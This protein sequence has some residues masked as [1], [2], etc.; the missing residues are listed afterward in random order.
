MVLK[1]NCTSPPKPIWGTFATGTIWLFESADG[2]LHWSPRGARPLATAASVAAGTGYASEEGANENDM[3]VLADG[4]LL[5]VFR[6]DGG[7]GWPDHPHA[8]FMS[9]RS[10]DMGL[11]WD[12]PQA[13][14]AGVLSARPRLLMLTPQ[15]P[16]LLTGGRPH[17]QLWVSSDGTGGASTWEAYNIAREHNA[18]QTDPA[19]RYCDAFANGS[20]TWLESTCYNSLVRVGD[21]CALSGSGGC[22][23]RALVCYDRMGTEAPVAPAACQPKEINTFCMQITVATQ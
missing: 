1:W 22:S 10:R 7:D 9:V 13:L 16:L 4:S 6:V 3:A 2:G 21:S 8:P 18:R 20:S 12:A 17:L 14:P 15:G 5:V 23:P 19:L 11:T